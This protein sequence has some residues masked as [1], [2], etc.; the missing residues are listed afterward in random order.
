MA[1][2]VRKY[3]QYH[4]SPLGHG[5]GK[6]LRWSLLGGLG[7]C[8]SGCVAM[9]CAARPRCTSTRLWAELHPPTRTRPRRSI[10]WGAQPAGWKWLNWLNMFVLP[11]WPSQHIKDLCSQRGPGQVSLLVLHEEVE[12]G[13]VQ[14]RRSWGSCSWTSR[15]LYLLFIPAQEHLE[16]FPRFPKIS[17]P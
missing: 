15:T 12:Q 1:K 8:G 9:F 17:K 7:E 2:G 5:E 10:A 16:C 14:L 4:P 13:R 11:H 3:Y 6:L